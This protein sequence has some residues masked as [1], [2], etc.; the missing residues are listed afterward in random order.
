MGIDTSEVQECLEL[1]FDA[2]HNYH[3]VHACDHVLF[4]AAQDV[5]TWNISR[6]IR[7]PATSTTAAHGSADAQAKCTTPTNCASNSCSSNTN[8]YFIQTVLTCHSSS[9]LQCLPTLVHHQQSLA[10]ELCQGNQH[11]LSTAGVFNQKRVMTQV[12][13]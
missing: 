12:V 1:C 7:F 3:N 2:P 8:Y 6:K 10:C 11:M 9:Y 13:P 4:Y 5:S